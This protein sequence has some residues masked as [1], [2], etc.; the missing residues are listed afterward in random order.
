MATR[1]GDRHRSGLNWLNLSDL[2]LDVHDVDVARG[3]PISVHSVS[4]AMALEP[5]CGVVFHGGFNI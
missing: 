3:V 1:S 5:L 2:V 4:A